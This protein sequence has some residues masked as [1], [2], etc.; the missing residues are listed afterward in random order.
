MCI[1]PWTRV[2]T[3]ALPWNAGAVVFAPAFSMWKVSPISILG[4]LPVSWTSRWAPH[5]LTAVATAGK[6]FGHPVFLAVVKEVADA[7]GIVMTGTRLRCLENRSSGNMGRL[8]IQ[9]TRATS[10]QAWLHSAGFAG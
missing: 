3:S 5:G 1:L 7:V 4:R 2:G 8:G 9:S 6:S 10:G